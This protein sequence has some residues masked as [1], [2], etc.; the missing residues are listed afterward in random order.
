[1]ISRRDFHNINSYIQ[2]V[3]SWKRDHCHKP[4]NLV[5]FSQTVG[6]GDAIL[7]IDQHCDITRQASNNF[8][9]D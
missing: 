7:E 5:V 9:L 8:K 2:N 3:L 6:K 4:A 1:M